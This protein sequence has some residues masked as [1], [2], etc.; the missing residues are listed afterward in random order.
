MGDYNLLGNLNIEGIP[1]ARPPVFDGSNFQYRKHRMQ[2]YIQG[3]NF[4][5]WKMVFYELKMPKGEMNTYNPEEV[6]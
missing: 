6:K 5:L 2:F 4:D 3:I 1:T